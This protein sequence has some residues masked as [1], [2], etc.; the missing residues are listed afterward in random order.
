MLGEAHADLADFAK[1]VQDMFSRN[2]WCP[3]DATAE[4]LSWV[5][6]E[7]NKEADA[8]A[9]LAMDSGEDF[10]YVDPEAFALALA[11]AGRGLLVAS[12][13]ARRTDT[14]ASSAWVVRIAL[15]RVRS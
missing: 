11:G 6:R 7:K 1:G 12:D 13:G 4:V 8:L 14:M 15:T 5:P 3:R 10:F 9:N 2:L